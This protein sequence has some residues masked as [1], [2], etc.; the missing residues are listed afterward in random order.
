MVGFQLIR[1][2]EWNMT[3]T[4]NRWKL[5][6]VVVR[7]GGQAVVHATY[8]R[9]CSLAEWFTQYGDGSKESAV[10]SVACKFESV[11]QVR[12]EY[13][14]VFNEESPHENSIRCWN[15]QLKEMGSLLDK[16]RSGRPII[17]DESVE[18]MW[19]S[20][21][22]NPKKSGHKCAWELRAFKNNCSQSFQKTSMFSWL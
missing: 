14:Q 1:L 6:I 20:F 22:C 10:C 15:R 11:T 4:W 5:G 9:L 12:H 19:N 21:I 17:S 18:N 13:C 8:L 2:L 7:E 16:Q 3:Y